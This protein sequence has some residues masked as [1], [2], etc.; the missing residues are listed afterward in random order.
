VRGCETPPTPIVHQHPRYRFDA[1]CSVSRLACRQPPADTQL[2][3]LSDVN[4]ALAAL[5]DT[6]VLGSSS[7]G[8]LRHIVGALACVDVDRMNDPATA[9]AALRAVMVD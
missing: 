9:A 1:G 4:A 2:D 7:D 5:P 8:L 6:I 3:P